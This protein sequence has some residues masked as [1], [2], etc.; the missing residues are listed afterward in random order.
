ML[1][2]FS[3]R[4][5]HYVYLMSILINYFRIAKLITRIYLKFRN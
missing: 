5:Q 4:G 3:Y 2:Y 1:Y